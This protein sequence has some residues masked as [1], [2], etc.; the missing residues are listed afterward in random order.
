MARQPDA[1]T[2]DSARVLYHLQRSFSPGDN[3]L[4]AQFWFARQLTLVGRWPEARLI[5]EALA[6]MKLPFANRNKILGVVHDNQ[7]LPVRFYGAVSYI[8]DFFGFI[9]QVDPSLRV[10]F[11]IS[12][13][14]QPFHRNDRISYSLGFTVRGPIATAIERV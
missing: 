1:D 12:Q 9:A 7:G 10:F 8:S 4:E 11:S 5:F 6:K 2:V 14:D 13:D 3:N